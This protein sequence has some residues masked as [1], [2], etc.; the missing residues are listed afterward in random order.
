MASSSDLPPGWEARVQDDGRV[1]YVDHINK[2]TT[3][4][5]PQAPPPPGWSVKTTPSGQVY[6]ENHVTKTTQWERPVAPVAAP[7]PGVSPG[8]WSVKTTPSG[9]VYYENHV[10]KTTQWERPVA[11]AAA[12]VPGVSPGGKDIVEE[13]G[14]M[15]RRFADRSG[16]QKEL[17]GFKKQLQ[18]LKA[19]LKEGLRTGVEEAQR[20]INEGKQASAASSVPMAGHSS[21][22]TGDGASAG[23]HHRTPQQE[24]ERHLIAEERRRAQAQM[25][26]VT[27]ANNQKRINAN[28]RAGAGIHFGPTKRVWVKEDTSPY[29]G[30]GIK[31]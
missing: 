8:G 4:D 30:A 1:Y 17:Q 23:H 28:L 26:A 2:I 27:I 18:P 24:L 5:K 6:Y 10:T 31:F 11:P 25:N 21:G 22:N 29:G 15:L 12:P 19:Q 20:K 7:A 13:G 3:Y 16:L 14:A 9:Q